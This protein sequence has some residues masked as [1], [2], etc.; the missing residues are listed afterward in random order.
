[1]I[2]GGGRDF[3]PAFLWGAA[4]AAHQVEGGLTDNDWIDWE[5]A[6]RT[7]DP[8]GAGI[9]QWR[10]WPTD[11]ALLAELGHT[12][13]R[14][15]IE[16]SRLAPSRGVW[17]AAAFD[18]YA[19][20]LDGLRE[21]GLTAFVTLQ[22]FTLPRW[23][24]AAGGWLAPDAPEIFAEFAAEAGR[25]LGDRIPFAGTVNEPQIVAFNG[26]LKG[27]HPPG[28]RDRDRTVTA[29][30]TLMRAHDAAV[31]ALRATAPNTRVG[32]CLQLPLVQPADPDSVDDV[33]LANWYRETLVT[34]HLEHLRDAPDAGDWVGVQYYTRA[35]VN[36]ALEQQRLGE[37]PAG[38]PTTQ[39]GWEVYPDGLTE[40]LRLAGKTTGLPIYIT[41]NG[42]ATTDDAE[43]VAYLDSHLRAV[44]AA[45]ADGVDVRGYLHWS[46][47]DNFE[48][49]HGY[50]PRFG[51]IGIDRDNDLQRVIHPSAHAYHRVITTGR[52]AALHEPAA[53]P[54][55]PSAAGNAKPGADDVAP[56]PDST[57]H[58]PT[59][60]GGGVPG[61][62]AEA[63]P[64]ARSATGG[65]AKADPARGVPRARTEAAPAGS[66]G[67]VH[68]G[69]GSAGSSPGGFPAVGTNPGV[70]PAA[71]R[72]E[73]GAGGSAAI[74]R[75]AS[76][77]SG[78]SSGGSTNAGGHTEAEAAHSAPDAPTQP[79]DRTKPGTA[80]TTPDAPTQPDGRAKPGT[81]HSTS[82]GSAD[83]GGCVGGGAG[84]FSVGRSGLRCGC[85]FHELSGRSAGLSKEMPV[86]IDPPVVR[87]LQR[88]AA[89]AQPESRDLALRRA[90]SAATM[91][92]AAFP[93]GPD[94]E[95]TEHTVPVAGGDIAVRVWRPRNPQTPVPAYFFL[96]G[97]GWVLGNLDTAEAECG[98]VA[99]LVPCA[100]VHV[101]Y[102]LAPEHPF[103]TP[104]DDCLTA[105]AW[106]LEH[107]DELGIDPNL[108]AIGGASAGGNLAAAMCLA[109]R[110]RGLPQ[111]SLQVLDAAP[112]DLTPMPDPAAAGGPARPG[113]S[114]AEFNMFA[115]HYVPEAEA[116]VNP[117][118]SPLRAADLSGLAPALVVVAEYDPLRDQAEDYLAALRAADVPA[119][120]IR[121]LGHIHGGWVVPAT[122]THTL[123]NEMR[124]AALRHAFAGT[125][126]GPLT[127]RLIDRLAAEPAPQPA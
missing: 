23:F 6:G 59:A 127:P 45:L 125:L 71:G 66:G 75:A 15:S 30:E 5:D 99:S 123:V 11:I 58:A 7:A 100:V 57:T 47:F 118:V 27:N 33:E 74:G 89:G 96:H 56:E 29:N 77:P 110:D 10:R 18:H 52:I 84:C 92:L 79:D 53:D 61:A 36:A 101:D 19:R 98:P 76:G 72:A 85:E 63:A 31:T 126:V 35:R 14:M 87:L 97:G 93:P 86:R 22:H 9:D 82:D 46:A 112:F 50:R 109:L 122:V 104:L 25:R 69:G 65:G 34:R 43:R 51:L 81:G 116:A 41:E 105:Y 60:A 37:P 119:A 32:V 102:R 64:T 24:A 16:W 26:Y 12:A 21:H 70:P 111:P 68:A 117:L 121:V 20:V 17:D 90:Q 44:R 103:P 114:V 124:A 88:V 120:G 115:R 28:Y 40:M 13:H 108:V 73:S 54:N 4:T 62:G 107:A 42:I 106:L 39:M 80:H 2:D 91:R 55:G 3:P 67:G 38:T 95:V 1:M 94:I 8:S 78:F 83:P 49:T 48:W 113:L